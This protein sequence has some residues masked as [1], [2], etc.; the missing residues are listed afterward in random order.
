MDIGY[1]IPTNRLTSVLSL[2]FIVLFITV[3]GEIVRVQIPNTL[4]NKGAKYL[5]MIPILLEAIK[6]QQQEI[7]SQQKL[8]DNLNTEIQSLKK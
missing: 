2:G 5:Q 3:S 8:I 7:Q 1:G 6:E 4:N